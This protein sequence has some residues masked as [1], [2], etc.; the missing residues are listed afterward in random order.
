MHVTLGQFQ[1]IDRLEDQSDVNIVRIVT[2]KTLKEVR[3]MPSHEVQQ[4]ALDVERYLS[5]EE[6]VFSST[7]FIDGVEYGF[8]P[9][10]EDI[11]YGE[12]AD[13]TDYIKSFET[14]DKAMAVAYRPVVKR[15]G[16]GQ[17]LIEDYEGS[18]KYSEIMK[19][20]PLHVV[21]GMQVFFYSLTMDLLT[22][23]PNFSSPFLRKTMEQLSSQ[24]SGVNMRKFL[25]LL[26]VISDASKV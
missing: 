13:L 12:N 20:A 2:G 17:Y 5:N 23:T 4:I 24:R 19:K 18:G 3:K 1:E 11:T 10:L 21:Q 26:K 8:I 25:H 6:H 15:N 14:M 16:R 22:C 7:F 9:N